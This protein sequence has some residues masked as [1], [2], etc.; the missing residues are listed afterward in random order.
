VRSGPKFD[1]RNYRVFKH[2]TKGKAMAT[3]QVKHEGQIIMPANS[4]GA[5][6]EQSRNFAEIQA[7]LSIAA[8][9]PRNEAQ[10]M[11]RIKVACQRKG[12]AEK[13]EYCYKR[14][15]TEVIGPTI[16]MLEVVANC[17]GNIQF[18]FREVA[19]RNGES[20]VESFAWDLETNTK[21]VVTFT[22][23]HKRHTSSGAYDLVD[24]R[25]IYEMVANN[26]ARRTRACLEAI[27]PPDVVEDAVN[28]ARRTLKA[29]AE[30]T[31]ESLQA[32]LDAFMP[33]DVDKEMI[34]TRLGRKLDSMQ[35][36]QLVSMRR[37]YK[38]I[39]DGMS[40]VEEWFKAKPKPESANGGEG[41]AGSATATLKD[42]LKQSVEKEKAQNSTPEQAGGPGD[43]A[44][45]KSGP[46][47][48]EAGKA[49]GGA[50]TEPSGQTAAGT[51]NASAEKSQDV[52]RGGEAPGIVQVDLKP[53]EPTADYWIRALRAQPTL[54][55][56]NA[57]W[58]KAEQDQAM[59][60][61][62]TSVVKSQYQQLVKSFTRK[63]K[64]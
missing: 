6:G 31:P 37:I 53:D 23:P 51:E 18:G 35:P 56:L 5:I 33:L 44:A 46:E 47:A 1:A 41:A 29:T 50:E 63:P 58:L 60:V 16:D 32:L 57:A 61:S 45:E 38:S 28:E 55:T 21:R 34:E 10:A 7:A 22:V 36:A 42:A 48:T 43:A 39:K 24:P 13:A 25:D 30:V 4:I 20:E 12:L 62:D 54:E 52:E 8:A 2:S 15:S 64:K 3:P 14:G 49:S 17:W 59:D 40:T 9:R 11:E 27:I 19:Q 26:A